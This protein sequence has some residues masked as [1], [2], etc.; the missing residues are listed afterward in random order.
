MNYA[1]P[2][3]P[4]TYWIGVND[5]E[6]HLF[7]ALWPLP[8]G[9]SYNAYI[10]CDNKVALI[11]TVKINASL[12]YL[13]K[14]EAVLQAGKTVDYLIINHMEP[15]HSGAIK[16]LLQRF[17]DMQIVGNQKTMG[18]LEGFYGITNNLKVVNDGD[19][20][21]L[22]NHTLRFYLTPMVHWPETMM[23]YDETDKVLF[24]GD[25]FGGFGTLDGGIFD[26]EVNI[27]FYEDEIRRYFSNIVG[28]YGKMVLKAIEKLKALEISTIAPTHGPVWRRNP[29]RIV[30][31]YRRWSSHETEAGVVIVYGSMYGNTERMTDKIARVLSEEG[32][33]NVRVFNAS[34]THI[35]YIIND[36]WRFTGLILGS[37]TY[38]TGLFPPMDNLIRT[39]ENKMMHNRVLGIFG[40]YSWSGGGVKAL[41]AFGNKGKWHLIDP[42]V[43]AQYA[44]NPQDMEQC[45]QLAKNMA[46]ELNA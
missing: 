46:Q 13:E 20:L 31:D 38:N 7:E 26:D 6:T 32:I 33:E 24:S 17:P 45:V 37:C 43:E 2:I 9:V 5:R 18:F 40:S 19:T 41:K 16:T 11:D 34:K 4:D 14:I 1:V 28:K 12:S 35:S 42:I 8:E 30:E 25:A 23:T 27:A 39:L 15:D 44:P 22:G 29:E 21:E 36:I 10:I 3:H